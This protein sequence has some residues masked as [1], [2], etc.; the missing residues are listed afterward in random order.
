MRLK[1][2]TRREPYPP[3]EC[4]ASRCHEEP[5]VIVV[6]R[7][8]D[9]GIVA[10]APEIP[11]ADRERVPLCDRHWTERCNTTEEDHG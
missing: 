1:T 10:T 2:K 6:G 11:E 9:G 5:A 4:A 7:I 3:R 8:D